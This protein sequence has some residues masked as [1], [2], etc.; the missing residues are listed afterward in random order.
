MALLSLMLERGAEIE[1]SRKMIRIDVKSG[2]IPEA[3]QVLSPNFDDRPSGCEPELIII[4][5]IS[6]PPGKFGGQWIDQ[7]FTNCLDSA[8]H[9]YFQEI[10]EQRVSSHL[11]I[12]RDGKLVQFVPLWKRAWHAG[13]SCYKDRERCN[14]YSIGIELEGAD[15]VAYTDCQYDV[16]CRTISGLRR[17]IP[18]LETAPIVGHSDVAPDR[19]TDPGP[20]FD[21]QR[22][23]A[24]LA[25]QVLDQAP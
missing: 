14:D 1:Y 5:G 13:T 7:L 23:H 25:E 17:A 4:H 15:T 22:L 9:P 12:R 20:A 8:A 16:L 18:S 24:G 19:K 3:H 10:A 21:W 6:L 11:L 2:L